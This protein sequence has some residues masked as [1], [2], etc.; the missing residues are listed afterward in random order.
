[1][2]FVTANSPKDYL[3]GIGL[4]TSRFQKINNAL[5][6]INKKLFK[7]KTYIEL[8]KANQTWLSLPQNE[9]QAYLAKLQPTIPQFT[10]RGAEIVSWGVNDGTED[11]SADYTFFAIWNFPT[12]DMVLEFEAL[13]QGADWYS[14]FDQVNLCGENVGPQHVIEKLMGL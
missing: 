5:K 12:N 2:L 14:F 4:R 1:M 8:W 3:N 13:L 10:N 6:L 7:M 11:H 9:R